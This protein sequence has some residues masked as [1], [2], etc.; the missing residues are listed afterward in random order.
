MRFISVLLAALTTLLQGCYSDDEINSAHKIITALPTEI[1]GCTFVADL[2]SGGFATI[3]NA[4]FY[5]KHL[6]VKAGGTHLV[7]THAVPTVISARTVGVILSGRAYKCPLG[8]GPKVESEESRTKIDLPSADML[9]GPDDDPPFS[10]FGFF[11]YHRPP[12]PHFM[13]PP[14]KFSGHPPRFM[15]PPPHR[16]PRLGH[17]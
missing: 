15:G 1:E 16:P 4:R 8:L 12:P 2:D 7:E 10:R 5:L 9:I 6:T 13:G 17:H 3:E 14:P 11:Y